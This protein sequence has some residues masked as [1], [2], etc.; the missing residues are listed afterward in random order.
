MDT[1]ALVIIEKIEVY[2]F[3][4]VATKIVISAHNIVHYRCY[5][6]TSQRKIND[7]L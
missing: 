6:L 7:Q 1:H 4:V 3:T 2:D 5:K